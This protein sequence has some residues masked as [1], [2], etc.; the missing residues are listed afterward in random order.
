[1]LFIRINLVNLKQTHPKCPREL[2]SVGKDNAKNMQG[3]GFEPR[4]PQK[5]THRITIFQG[6]RSILTE[7]TQMGY[8]CRD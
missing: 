4:T 2:G 3:P 8:T 7:A 1:M 5:K 6:L